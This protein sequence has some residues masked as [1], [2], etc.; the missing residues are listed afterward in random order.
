[1]RL[2][3][4]APAKINLTL[5]VLSK[6]NDGYHEIRSVIQTIDLYDVITIEDGDGQSFR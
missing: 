5:E 6:R 1:M 2:T 3:V 4:R